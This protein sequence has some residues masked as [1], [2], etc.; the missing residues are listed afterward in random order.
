MIT[1]S[2]VLPV[3]SAISTAKPPATHAPTNGM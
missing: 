1:A 2:D 3:L